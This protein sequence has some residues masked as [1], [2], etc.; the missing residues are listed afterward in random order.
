M[1]NL[2]NNLYKISSEEQ[3][4]II[5]GEKKR[6]WKVITIERSDRIPDGNGNYTWSLR[7]REALFVNGE[8]TGKR[9]DDK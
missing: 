1:K 7:T 8:D 9:R 6:E 5:G 4:K 3:I 2:K